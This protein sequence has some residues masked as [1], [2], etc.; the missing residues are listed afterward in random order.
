[1]LE[2]NFRLDAHSVLNQPPRQL[3][4]R[5][6]VAGFQV[7]SVGGDIRETGFDFLGRVA[8]SNRVQNGSAS[9]APVSAAAETQS[10]SFARNFGD[11]SVN[12]D[13]NDSINVGA[14]TS[15][16]RS[17]TNLASFASLANLARQESN[18]VNDEINIDATTSG[19]AF[20]NIRDALNFEN[21]Q[22]LELLPAEETVDADFLCESDASA[23][24]LH[25]EGS[26]F[27]LSGL[28]IDDTDD[29]GLTILFSESININEFEDFI[30]NDLDVEE[31]LRDLNT[32]ELEAE[33]C[34]RANSGTEPVTMVAMNNDNNE[35]ESTNDGNQNDGVNSGTEPVAM[36][37]NQ[38]DVANRSGILYNDFDPFKRVPSSNMA[39]TVGGRR[40]AMS[41][42]YR[43]LPTIHENEASGKYS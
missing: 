4:R 31:V 28:A 2:R 23:G 26:D 34:G 6:S 42:D 19:S 38:N 13:N 43:N 20:C 10:P 41:M 8:R 18:R 1:M 32:N 36:D 5:A 11:F 17:D 9:T 16:V 3:Q 30:A 39:F 22:L 40:R 7:Y 24:D 21:E 29:F 14:S 35:A 37:G 33:D 12:A 25:S 15:G 27:G